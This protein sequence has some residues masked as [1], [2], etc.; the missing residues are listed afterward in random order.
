MNEEQPQG[1]YEAK[2]A[3]LL[4]KT[5]IKGVVQGIFCDA[6]NKKSTLCPT[7]FL[8]NSNVQ[9]KGFKVPLLEGT[10]GSDPE[11]HT[12][13]AWEFLPP[14]GALTH[15]WSPIVHSPNTQMLLQLLGNMIMQS[16]HDLKISLSI[17]YDVYVCVGGARPTFQF[18]IF[19]FGA[20]V[21]LLLSGCNY[22]LRERQEGSSTQIAH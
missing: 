4:Q 1:V 20:P 11:S 5:E 12:S 6:L 21:D 15:P 13:R 14:G 18:F 19:V 8:K 2:E 16:I 3:S 17:V 7:I 22:S 10:C 9:A